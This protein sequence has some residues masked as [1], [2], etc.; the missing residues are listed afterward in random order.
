MSPDPRDEVPRLTTALS[1]VLLGLAGL[2]TAIAL[3]LPVVQLNRGE[4]IATV[5]LSPQATTSALATVT[6]P[7]G[8]VTATG[9]D[10]VTVNLVVTELPDGEPV[11]PGAMVLTQVGTC[12]WLLGL[13]AVCFLLARV[14]ADIGA[15]RPFVAPQ[16]RR[17]TL[18]A[19]AIV[20][21]SA[22]AD[23]VNYLQARTLTS[24]IGDPSSLVVTPYYSPIPLV[25]AAVSLVLA[26][27]FRSGRRM[28]EETEG[29]I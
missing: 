23:T 3:A 12:L 21:C 20:V 8:L 4:A 10:R 28:Q 19:A 14:L 6:V 5:D 11:S 13:A 27:A 18:I 15:G 24:A 7:T 22:G 16:S 1:V 25:L 9:N 26:G 2:L 29:L 17:F